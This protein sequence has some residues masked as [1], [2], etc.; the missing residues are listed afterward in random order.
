MTTQSNQPDDTS[1]LMALYSE[2]EVE[3]TLAGS[4]A[5]EEKKNEEG[6]PVLAMDSDD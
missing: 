6:L 5:S 1:P 4:V 3:G 2:S